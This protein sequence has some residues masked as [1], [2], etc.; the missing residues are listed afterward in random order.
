MDLTFRETLP[1]DVEDLFLVRA[2]TSENPISKEQLAELGITADT[3]TRQ[4]SAGRIKGCVCLDDSDVVGFCHGDAESGEVLALV[5]L[6]QYE[7]KGVGRTLLTR[8]A[9]QLRSIGCS[10]LWLA[11]S[12]DATTRAHGFYRSLGWRPN[13]ETD[14]NDDEILVLPRD[15]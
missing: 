1:S 9:E 13:G 11:A 8:V 6:P 4:L 12:A 7:G 3:I 15:T 14:E 2:R 5:V 10:D